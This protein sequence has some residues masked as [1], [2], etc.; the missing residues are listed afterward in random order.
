MKDLVMIGNQSAEYRFNKFTPKRK[1]IMSQEIGDIIFHNNTLTLKLIMLDK[2]KMLW[3]VNKQKFSIICN[4]FM[5]RHST[6][7]IERR[8]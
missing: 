1:G 8:V 2:T 5:V 4:T 3:L 7:N 6:S